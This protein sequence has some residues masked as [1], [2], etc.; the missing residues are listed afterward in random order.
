VRHEPGVTG[1]VLIERSGRNACN[2]CF[3]NW[4][5]EKHLADEV[6]LPG[7]C[8]KREHDLVPDIGRFHLLHIIFLITGSQE[9]LHYSP[10][11]RACILFELHCHRLNGDVG[12]CKIKTS[13]RSETGGVFGFS[14]HGRATDAVQGF[15]AF[16]VGANGDQ[17]ADVFGHKHRLDE[18]FINSLAFEGGGSG[19]RKN[20]G[21]FKKGLGVG[22]W[23]LGRRLL[24]AEPSQC[25][26]PK[27]AF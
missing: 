14:E 5:C 7:L 12:I 18:V 1:V 23:G 4:I 11:E 24:R 9:L 8:D 3:S 16:D 10:P 19:L 17:S 13:C 26:A 2:K 22:G 6:V 27:I 15:S 21:H 20:V 25:C